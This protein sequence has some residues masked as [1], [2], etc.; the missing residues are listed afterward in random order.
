MSRREPTEFRPIRLLRPY[1]FVGSY[2]SCAP[3]VTRRW[4]SRAY[5]ESLCIPTGTVGTSEELAIIL[6]SPPLGA[7]SLR[8]P[9]TQ[10]SA[11]RLRRT[12]AP[13]RATC[14]RPVGALLILQYPHGE[15]I[16]TRA[17]GT[18]ERTSP[19]RLRRARA[20]YDPVP[21]FNGGLRIGDCRFT[22]GD[23]GEGEGYAF[24]RGPWERVKEHPP[25]LR[26]TPFKGGL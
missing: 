2:R 24:P 15:I 8:V 7:P 9:S 21:P 25:A 17:V 3:D 22:I 16:P 23:W 11:F 10:G 5:P 14:N 26:A 20:G 13:P 4:E 1:G 6:P 12:G 18:S 19:G